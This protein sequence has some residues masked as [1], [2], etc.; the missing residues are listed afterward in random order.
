MEITLPSVNPLYTYS[1]NNIKM[2]YGISLAI[3]TRTFKRVDGDI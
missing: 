1:E 2:L 3:Y